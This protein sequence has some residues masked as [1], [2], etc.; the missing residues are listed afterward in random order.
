MIEVEQIR[1]KIAIF[2]NI[3]V[4]RVTDGTGLSDLIGDSSYFIEMILQ[5]EEEFDIRIPEE[6]L[7]EVKTVGELIEVIRQSA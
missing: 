5:I 3:P 1:E 2:L 4:R 7:R 6:N